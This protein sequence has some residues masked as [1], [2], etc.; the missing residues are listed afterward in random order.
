MALTPSNMEPDKPN[1]LKGIDYEGD[2]TEAGEDSEGLL[3]LV[4]LLRISGSPGGAGSTDGSVCAAGSVVTSATASLAGASE[5]GSMSAMGSVADLAAGSGA[6]P[7]G[8]RTGLMG[9]GRGR[10]AVSNVPLANSM[11]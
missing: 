10:L 4:S 5:T 6:S 3:E 9:L 8:F 1:R 11:T 7:A 2:S